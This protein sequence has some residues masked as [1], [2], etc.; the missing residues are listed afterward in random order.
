MIEGLALPWWMS[1]AVTLSANISWQTVC[2]SSAAAK[3]LAGV[4]RMEGHCCAP[5]HVDYVGL[6]GGQHDRARRSVFSLQKN[7]VITALQLV[8]GFGVEVLRLFILLVDK[9]ADRYRAC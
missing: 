6:P 3:V 9:Q 5:G 7:C 4:E 8:A 1:E 2:R